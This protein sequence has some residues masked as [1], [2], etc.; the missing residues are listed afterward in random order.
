MY[1]DLYLKIASVR[2]QDMREQAAHERLLRRRS[3]RQA[4]LA[5]DSRCRFEL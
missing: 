2:V 4:C 5:T 1:P 3:P